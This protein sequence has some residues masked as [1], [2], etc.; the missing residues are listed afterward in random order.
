M[1]RIS[2]PIVDEAL[3]ATEATSG[4]TVPGAG[5]PS[6]IFRMILQRLLIV[7]AHR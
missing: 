7:A 3:G 5:G 6:V 2:L 4:G 1:R